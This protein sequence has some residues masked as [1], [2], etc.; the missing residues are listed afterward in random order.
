[1][2]DVP[3]TY[4]SQVWHYLVRRTKDGSVLVQTDSAK[5]AVRFCNDHPDSANVL[6]THS[7]EIVHRNY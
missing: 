4:E 7:G 2:N 6:D 3:E 1:M 5:A